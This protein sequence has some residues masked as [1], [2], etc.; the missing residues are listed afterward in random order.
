MARHTI[1]AQYHDASRIIIRLK[2]KAREL[3]NNHKRTEQ[4]LH[5][6]YMTIARIKFWCKRRLEIISKAPYYPQ[7]TRER[8]AER[9]ERM[10]EI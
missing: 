8:L 1:Q 7:I 5:E 10:V 9:L 3:K 2:Q 6:Y 4:S